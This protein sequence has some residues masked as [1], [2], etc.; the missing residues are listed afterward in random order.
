[1]EPPLRSRA[2]IIFFFQELCL[3]FRHTHPHMV[4]VVRI[5]CLHNH[6]SPTTVS[7]L[8]VASLP[9]EAGDVASEAWLVGIHEQDLPL[10]EAVPASACLLL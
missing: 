4:V 10:A 6:R 2:F 8:D 5:V 7:H 3:E 9:A 1:M